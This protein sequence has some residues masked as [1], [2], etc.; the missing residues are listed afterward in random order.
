MSRR[1][2][3]RLNPLLSIA[4]FAGILIA[5]AMTDRLDSRQRLGTISCCLLIAAIEFVKW[6]RKK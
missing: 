6:M 1:F 2:Q 3:F 5:L 4:G